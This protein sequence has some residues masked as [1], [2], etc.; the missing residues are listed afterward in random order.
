MTRLSTI[1]AVHSLRGHWAPVSFGIV[2]AVFLAMTANGGSEPRDTPPGMEVLPAKVAGAVEF[3][4]GKF[5]QAIKLKDGKGLRYVCNAKSFP[6]EEGTFSC[7]LRAPKGVSKVLFTTA[8]GN[9]LLRIW[10]HS[11]TEK[12]AWQSVVPYAGVQKRHGFCQSPMAL[13]NW[14][15]LTMTWILNKDDPNG[16]GRLHVYVNGLGGQHRYQY[17]WKAPFD[18]NLDPGDY[19]DLGLLPCEIDDVVLLDKFL[20]PEEVRKMYFSGPHEPG[21]RT[22]MHISFDGSKADGVVRRL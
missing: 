2:T 5:G 11:K 21:E 19:F 7:W 3:V 15:Q 14:Y 20:T 1:R 18:Y 16:K 12:G 17:K 8:K 13:D 4:P 10:P 22:R 9:Y 6:V